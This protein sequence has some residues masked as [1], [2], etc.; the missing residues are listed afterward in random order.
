MRKSKFL[1]LIALVL[2]FSMLFVA[3][4][5]KDEGEGAATTTSGDAGTPAATPE[6]DI[7]VLVELMNSDPSAVAVEPIVYA[8]L[9]GINAEISDVKM[10]GQPIEDLE[11]TKLAVKDGMFY[12][13][14]GEESA[15]TIIDSSLAAVTISAEGSSVYAEMM[16]NIIGDVMEEMEEVEIDEDAVV[17]VEAS[18]FTNEGNGVYSLNKAYFEE[19]IQ[20]ALNKAAGE[21][22]DEQV[23]QMINTYMDVVKGCDLRVAYTVKNSAVVASEIAL[24]ISET[25]AAKIAELAGMPDLGE[26]FS[27]EVKLVTGLTNGAPTSVNLSVDLYMPMNMSNEE[28]SVM[29]TFVDVEGTASLDLANLAALKADVTYKMIGKQYTVNEN[30]FTPVEGEPQTMTST[31][32]A[33]VEN[34][35]FKFTTT[36]KMGEQEQNTEITANVSFGNAT[37]PAVSDAANEKLQVFN[38]VVA[39]KEKID[40]FAESLAAKIQA[41]CTEEML[42]EDFEYTYEEY[43]IEL[44]FYAYSNWVD[45]ETRTIVVEYSGFD[46]VDSYRSDYTVTVD[47][48]NVTIT[49]S[50]VS[51]GDATAATAV[52]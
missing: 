52:G 41:K 1:V 16:D 3:C 5:K 39:D 42:Y 27:G 31:M 40:A 22:P 34:G 36:S 45:S 15:W 9:S 28:S 44:K 37:I 26:K 17:A 24:K 50:H 46:F 30:T 35:V 10:N 48:E 2:C 49:P 19:A 4:S 8:M 11:I 21:N 18:D 6:D 29:V 51:G 43:G 47:G 33:G 23:T 14:N 32:K 13:T 38:K 12:I 7:K 25:T 20:N